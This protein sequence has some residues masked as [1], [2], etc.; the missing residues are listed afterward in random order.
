MNDYYR[1]GQMPTLPPEKHGGRTSL[2]PPR[3]V[4]HD[5][6]AWLLRHLFFIGSTAL[7]WRLL[8]SGVGA[9]WAAGESVLALW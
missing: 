8:V 7:Q 5:P 4:K 9:I 1:T 6:L 2:P 3:H